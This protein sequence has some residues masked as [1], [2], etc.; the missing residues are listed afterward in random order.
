MHWDA[1]LGFTVTVRVE[2]LTHYIAQVQSSSHHRAQGHCK[3]H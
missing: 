2:T 3:G 1:L